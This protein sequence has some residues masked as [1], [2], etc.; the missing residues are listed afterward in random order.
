MKAKAKAVPAGEI[1]E[2]TMESVSVKIAQT[3]PANYYANHSRLT[4][5]KWDFAF[6]FGR[7]IPP[8]KRPDGANVVEE[9]MVY[10]SPQHAK[11]F[12]A[13]LVRQVALY[14]EKFGLIPDP[15]KKASEKAAEGTH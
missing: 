10:M 8:G 7:M 3:E 1:K 2:P 9:V 15:N 14:E 5:N 4:I 11:A 12:M 6:L 13:L